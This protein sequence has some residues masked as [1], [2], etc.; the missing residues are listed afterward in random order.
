MTMMK[1]LKGMSEVDLYQK[2]KVVM[3]HLAYLSSV[4]DQVSPHWSE[5]ASVFAP[6]RFREHLDDKNRASRDKIRKVYDNT[7]QLARRICSAGL[8]SGIT[9][10][11][12]PWFKLMTADTDLNEFPTVK[13]WLADVAKL[14]RDVYNRSNFY[15]SLGTMYGELSTFGTGV[16]L[17]LSDYDTVIHAFDHT[18]GEYYLAVNEKNEVDTVFRQF[19]WTVRQVVKEFGIENVS[20]KIKEKVQN[21][22]LFHEIDVLHVIQPRPWAEQD[23]ARGSNLDMPYESLWLEI[24]EG[25][26]H[27]GFLRISGYQEFPGCAPRWETV[28]GDTYGSN[29]PGMLAL[30]DGNGLQTE[31]KMKLSAITKMVDPP[32]AG[33]PELR[34]Q[35]I[36]TRPGNITYTSFVNGKPSLQSVYDVRFQVGDLKEDIRDVQERI[37]RAFFVDLFRMISNSDRN[38]ITAYEIQKKHEEKLLELGPVLEQMHPA[39]DRLIDRTFNTMMRA[40]MLPEPPEEAAGMDLQ[41]EYISVLAQA[42][43]AV[44]VDNIDRTATFVLSH[45]E[46]KPEMLDKLDGDAMVDEYSEMLGTPPRIIRS[47]EEVAELRAQRQQQQQAAQAMEMAQA[48]AKAAKDASQ[49]DPGQ[50]MLSSLT[51]YTDEMAVPES[52]FPE[53]DL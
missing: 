3:A 5:V 21:D 35:A 17:L 14:M 12:R 33:S 48:G 50:G 28:G 32:M 18:V 4:R 29:C 30:P 1:R 27:A 26:D 23:S 6:W 10:P 25:T 40:D 34:D 51:G 11:A 24:G 53:E 46:A 7:G 43:K 22:Q 39:L 52:A 37:E 9:S 44:G 42:Q 45:A 2:R 41:V 38:D 15:S 19:R 13:R 8:M 20:D 16:N 49:A 31:Q 47:A 36:S